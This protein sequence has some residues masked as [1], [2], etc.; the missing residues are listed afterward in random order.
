MLEW[1]AVHPMF[2]YRVCVFGWEVPQHRCLKHSLMILRVYN[3]QQESWMDFSEATRIVYERI[4]ML[5]PENV[6]KIIG[7]ILLQDDAECKMI[8]LARG[9]DSSIKSL[10]EA[11]KSEL[12]LS[13]PVNVSVASSPYQYP[14]YSPGSNLRAG[15]PCWDATGLG[16]PASYLCLE[17]SQKISSRLPQYPVKICRYFHNGFCRHGNNCRYFHGTPAM[18]DN[19]PQHFSLFTNY[20][21]VEERGLPQESLEKLELEITEL[22]KSQGRS[23]MSIAS[24][25]MLY[26]EK[27]GRSLQAEGY[28]TESQRHGKARFSLLKLLARLKSSIRLI[29]W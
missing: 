2:L 7:Y 25:P 5:E 11:A 21:V 13:M 6:S 14:P 27:Y 3:V 10:I 28:L 24:L 22:L 20:P 17:P 9:P 19:F 18:A 8:K 26:F 4:Q 16:F 23:P 29:D 12:R 15:N 1:S